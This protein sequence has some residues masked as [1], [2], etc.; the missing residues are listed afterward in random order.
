M[1]KRKPTWDR[2]TVQS[3]A[4]FRGVKRKPRTWRA[5]AMMWRAHT[6]RDKPLVFPTRQDIT[7]GFAGDIQ[8]FRVTITEELPK[9]RKVTR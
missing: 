2:E 9:P 4:D 3:I 7:E 5:W 8:P 1:T 6:G